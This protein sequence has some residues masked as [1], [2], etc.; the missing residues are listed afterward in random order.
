MIQLS[1]LFPSPRTKAVRELVEFVVCA[2]LWDRKP[3]GSK[4][5]QSAP[6]VA[7]E[8]PHPCV[9]P[10]YTWQQPSVLIPGLLHRLLA[11]RNPATLAD[12]AR[13]FEPYLQKSRAPRQK[14]RGD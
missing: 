11:M 9:Q 1:V 10:R 7:L 3:G 5:P 14:T 8:W 4:Y 2:S 12:W 13:H 6:T